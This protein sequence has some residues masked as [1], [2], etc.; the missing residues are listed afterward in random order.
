MSFLSSGLIVL[1]KI[2]EKTKSLI[3]AI[4]VYRKKTLFKFFV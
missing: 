1:E 4:E 2:G 3:D